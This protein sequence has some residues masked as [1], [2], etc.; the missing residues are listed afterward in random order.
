MPAW[1]IVLYLLAVARL[2]GLATVDTITAPAR[3]AL[4]SRFNPRSRAHR[5]LAYLVG[6]P[7]DDANGCPW[8]ASIWIGAAT[9]PLA[10]WWGTRPWVAIP[11]LALAASQV[12]GM[13]PNAAGRG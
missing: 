7:D 12:A 6:V 5:A 3:Q 13:V 8:C 4:V 10:W 11:A 1:V 2:A 9:A